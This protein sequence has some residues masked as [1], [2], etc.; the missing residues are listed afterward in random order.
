MPSGLLLPLFPLEVVLLPQAVLPL[1]IFEERYKL[2]VGEAIENNS[3]FGI[4][5]AKDNSLVNVGCT[6]AVQKVIRRY[7]DGRFDI[8]AVG[9]RRFEILFLDQQKPYVQAAVHFF[10]DEPE[11]AAESD[12]VERLAALFEQVSKFIPSQ[13]DAEPPLRERS[14]KQK[15]SFQ[16]AAALPLDLE[17][18]QRV[19][20]S[21]SEAE[22]VTILTGHLQNL[23]PR[24]ALARKVERSAR[25]NGRGR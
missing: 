4:V 19:L 6:A 16:I 22:R 8:L 12:A 5:L 14:Q 21:R 11:T 18:K 3:E 23:L 2:M 25:G 7:P 9:R 1:H 15:L 20:S 10:D 13:A 17:M 24:L